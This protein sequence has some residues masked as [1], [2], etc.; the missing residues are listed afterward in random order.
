MKQ[1]LSLALTLLLLAAPFGA[2]PAGA[3][4]GH[5]S[6]D[7]RD[8]DVVDV[9]RLLATEADASIITDD[10]VKHDK[11]TLHLRNVSFMQA[12]SVLSQAY[13]LQVRNEGGVLIVGTSSSMN[14]KYGDD[15][16]ALAPQ[17]VVIAV[18]NSNPDD[19]VKPLTDALEEGTIVV[20]DKRTGTLIITGD[21]SS[22][23]RARRL[24][25]ALDAPLAGGSE[26]QANAI[27]LRFVKADE[28]VKQL[29]GILPDNSYSAE[30]DQNT[31][32]VTG[33]AAVLSTARA[34]IA[35]IDV[36][37]PQVMF[38]VRVV[39]VSTTNDSNVGAIFGGVPQSPASSLNTPQT[40]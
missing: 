22:I 2:S 40:A 13:G 33:P 14:R 12:L 28:A 3:T 30:N 15:N 17:T 34:L 36:P 39:E 29:K 4:S 37:A 1:P 8:A 32:L 9:L 21:Q 24:I 23:A 27:H 7:V 38:E 35:A 6:I 18:Q 16:G 26:A 19:L 31:I 5:L 11:V 10:S 20:S 25:G